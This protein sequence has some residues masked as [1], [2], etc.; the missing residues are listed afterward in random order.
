MNIAIVVIIILG[1]QNILVT[2][3]NYKLKKLI[4]EYIEE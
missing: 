1:I 4:K 2:I 3:E